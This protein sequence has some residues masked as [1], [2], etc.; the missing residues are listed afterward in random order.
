L[1]ETEEGQCLLLVEAGAKAPD[2]LDPAKVACLDQ[3]VREVHRDFVERFTDWLARHP[4]VNTVVVALCASPAQNIEERAQVLG[5]ELVAVLDGRP[6]ARLLFGAPSDIPERQRRR[7]LGLTAKWARHGAGQRACIIGAHFSAHP[8][9][10]S[11]IPIP[12]L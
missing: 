10:S 5:T 6:K 3:R 4:S 7:L 8:P 12:S 1:S 2:W 11:K 9:S